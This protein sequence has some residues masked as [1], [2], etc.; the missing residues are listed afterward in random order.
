MSTRIY[1]RG[2]II[3]N[4]ILFVVFSF[5]FVYLQEIFKG[6]SSVTNK[7]YF[8]YFIKGHIPFVSI[9]GLTLITFL[10]Q[11]PKLGKLGFFL[12]SVLTSAL[13]IINL[14]FMFSKFVLIL[15]FFYI[16]I[17][18]Y[19]YQFYNVEYSES[20]YKSQINEELLFPP[21]LHQI[22]V[23]GKSGNGH[24]F[25]GYL[26]NWSEEG[27]YIYL[28]EPN[29]IKGKVTIEI[30]FQEHIFKA[31]GMIVAKERND[32]GVGVKF[33]LNANEESLNG[34]GWNEFYEIIGEMGLKPELLL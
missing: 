1:Y 10:V 4:L 23:S 12:S 22:K 20:Y 15:L 29:S 25:T 5:A 6:F 8:L 7:T 2:P 27:C 14:N 19:F 16:L 17:A 31:E 13:T 28:N 30:F 21:M 9:L 26:T 32:H 3:W 18:Y 24:Q 33:F 34:L 11:A